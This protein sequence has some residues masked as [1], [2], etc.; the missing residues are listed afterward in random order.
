[1]SV[2]CTFCGQPTDY[3]SASQ[4]ARLLGKADQVVTRWCREGRFPG[5]TFVPGI[6]SRGV[7]RIPASAVLPIAEEMEWS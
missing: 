5:A 3:M 7:W 2:P 6:Q 4:V 1:M